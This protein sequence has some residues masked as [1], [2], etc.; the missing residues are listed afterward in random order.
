MRLARGVKAVLWKLA[1]LPCVPFVT[2][3]I[4]PQGRTAGCQHWERREPAFSL[5]SS[6]CEGTGPG[7]LISASSMPRRMKRPRRVVQKVGAAHLTSGG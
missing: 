3:A 7:M 4:C 5:P 1:K 6:S 2:A